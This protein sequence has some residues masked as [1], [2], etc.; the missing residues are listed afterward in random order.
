MAP[1]LKSGYDVKSTLK[2][3]VVRCCSP[4]SRF[5]PPRFPRSPRSLFPLETFFP[6]EPRHRLTQRQPQ[7][8]SAGP[9]TEYPLTEYAFPLRARRDVDLSQRNPISARGTNNARD[10]LYLPPFCL[11]AWTAFSNEQPNILYLYSVL[12]T[13]DSIRTKSLPRTCLETMAG[14]HCEPI[15]VYLYRNHDWVGYVLCRR[16]RPLLLPFS[17]CVPS[18]FPSS[19]PSTSPDNKP[20]ACSHV[21]STPNFPQTKSFPLHPF[22]PSPCL[23]GFSPHGPRPSGPRRLSA[24]GPVISLLLSLNPRASVFSVFVPPLPLGSGQ[25]ICTHMAPSSHAIPGLERHTTH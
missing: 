13:L 10:P 2:W 11:G 1:K 17:S 18:S 19:F 22:L 8:D 3:T 4:R 6:Y 20:D 5:V 25:L 9:R 7:A 12:C 14:S 23:P 16:G 15:L 21:L 24:A